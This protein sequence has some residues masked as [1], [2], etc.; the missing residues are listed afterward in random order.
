MNRE[1]LIA[2]LKEDITQAR[3]VV[4]AGTGVSVAACGNQKVEGQAVAT[5]VGL[6]Q[7]G[8]Q[9]CKDIGAADES[10]A[11]LLAMQIKSGKTNFLISAA[12][13]ISQRMRTKAAGVFLGWLKNT[14]GELKVMD[15]AVLDT[16][17]AL[18]GVLATLNYDNLLEDATG[19]PAVTW[20][21]ADE[22][23][24]VLTRR[25]TDAVLHLH[26]WFKEPESVVLG[27]NSYLSVKNHPHA[28][29]VLN[30]FTLDRTLLFIGCGFSHS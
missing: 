13:D 19:R 20:L 9:H 17:A 22:V 25:V 7:H 4:I 26:G 10:D 1:T 23:Q 6:L 11:E 21:K 28:K 5:W 2:K 14:I 24:D 15:R 12:E 8:V 18:P 3:V 27:L 30:L 16:I 29:A